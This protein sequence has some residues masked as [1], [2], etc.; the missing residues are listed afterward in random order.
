MAL[1]T[2]HEVWDV[3][4]VGAGPAGSTAA[5]VAAESGAAVLLLDRAVFP[6]YKTCG[7][8]LVG[9]S[10]RTLPTSVLATVEQRTTTL[11][12]SFRGRRVSRHHASTPFL[13]MVRRA[14]FDD[15]LVAAA[16]AAGA[17]FA[18]G[19]QVKT[20]VDADRVVLGTSR[21]EIRARTVVG[22]DG[23]N[24]QTGRYVGVTQGGIDLALEYEFAD[25]GNSWSD[26]VYFD[27]GKAPGSYAWMFPKDGTITVGAIQ[28]KGAPEQTRA[29]LQTWVRQLGL[30]G[31]PVEHFSGHLTQWRTPRSPLRK[32]HVIVAGDAAGLLDPWTREGISFALRSGIHAG[33]A[34]AAGTE[35]AL[36]TYCATVRQELGGEIVSG[37]R[38][39]R[40]V[41]GHPLV[42]HCALS[43]TWVG[44]RLFMAICRGTATL[45]VLLDNRLAHRLRHP[46][47]RPVSA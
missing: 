43:Y 33:R 28:A 7:G 36:E 32:G 41:A 11:R 17:T 47:S 31:R 37:E 27:W 3:V 30:S 4:V 12:L 26:E 24:G 10:I 20:I 21:G 19:V 29:Y 42:L 1:I 13:S 46:L 38:V 40:F 35:H 22:A 23:T 16:I 18:E 14:Q 9:A 15:A 25:P 2:E 6:R 5:R 39:L 45:D 44:A 8:G 34:A